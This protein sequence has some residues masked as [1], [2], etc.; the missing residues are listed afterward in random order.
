M[1]PSSR[2]CTPQ[3]CRACRIS[4]PMNPAGRTRRPPGDKILLAHGDLLARGLDDFVRLVPGERNECECTPFVVVS[5]VLVFVDGEIPVGAAVNANLNWISRLF[6][7][8]LL[9]W[10]QR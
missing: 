5:V 3:R 9:I 10:A 8:P 1:G 7:R 4:Q 6:G 2:R